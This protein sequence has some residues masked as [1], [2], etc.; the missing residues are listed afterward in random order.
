MGDYVDNKK[1]QGE[2]SIYV[3]NIDVNEIANAVAKA[4]GNMMPVVGNYGGAVKKDDFFNDENSMKKIAESM[5]VQ[6]SKNE[7]NFDDLGGVVETK[8]DNNKLK[9]TLD[10]L[11]GLGD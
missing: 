2:S 10:L 8:K 6:R 3:N 4:V 7:S 11:S 1:M 5:I 9:S